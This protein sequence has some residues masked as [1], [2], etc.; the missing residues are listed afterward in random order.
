M[1]QECKSLQD[2]GREGLARALSQ[3]CTYPFESKKASLQVYG[4]IRPSPKV[5]NF[6]RGAMQSSFTSGF[7]FSSYFTIYNSLYPNP[8]ASSIASIITSFIKIPISNCMRVLQINH[9][10]KNFIESGKKIMKTK[11]ILG[12]Y[13][14]YGVSLLEDIIETNIRN[15]VYERSKLI[16]HIP[17]PNMKMFTGAIAGGLGAAITTPF[18]TIRANLAH[19]ATQSGEVDL[20]QMTKTLIISKEGPK[21]LFRGMH[22]RAA[23]NTVRYALFYLIME[24]L[25]LL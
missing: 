9:S 1:V 8:F 25:Y 11:G 10:H 19:H 18:D 23:S 4:N 21:A 22:L 24:S 2:G 7:V 12:L 14:G 16:I 15:Y 3:L 17:Y 5:V 13:S 6:Y 20:F